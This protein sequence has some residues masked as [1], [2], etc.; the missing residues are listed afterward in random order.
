MTENLST[1]D[2]IKTACD[3]IYPI[4]KALRTLRKYGIDSNV[5]GIAVSWE[6]AMNMLTVLK[7]EQNKPRSSS[8]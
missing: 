8:N 2:E 7:K 3:T 4:A 5:L 6:L 1:I